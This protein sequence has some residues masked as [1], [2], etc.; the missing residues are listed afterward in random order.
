MRRVKPAA[1]LIIAC[2]YLVLGQSADTG[3]KFVAADVHAVPGAG[4]AFRAIPIH[5][6]RYE[7]K[8]A[9]M[10]DMLRTAYGFEADRIVGDPSWLGMD[11]FD[12]AAKLPGEST[13]DNQ[14]LMLQTLLEDRFKLV[15]HKDTRPITG[16]VLTA[17]KKPT[18]RRAAS[19]EKS[20]GCAQ[21][22]SIRPGQW[23]ARHLQLPQ[24]DHG[25]VRA[26]TE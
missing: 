25:G 10:L 14:K 9:S 18:L 13:P 17:G 12:I 23:P 19:T 4:M 6:G 21:Q 15:V 5:H 8:N 22:A 26:G 16:Y 2:C 24:H 20:G 1:V 3:P 7:L 11:R